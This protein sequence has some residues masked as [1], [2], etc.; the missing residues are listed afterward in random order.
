MD[1]G[2][3]QAI[4]M[5]GSG[6]AHVME[7]DWEEI[8]GDID[9]QPRAGSTL[10]KED[11]FHAMRAQQ[12]FANAAANPDV[13]NKYYAAE[14]YASTIKDVDMQKAVRPE[15]PPSPQ[16]PKTQVNI[17]IPLDKMPY[18]V[19][20]VLTEMGLQPVPDAEHDATLQGIT[21]I[22]EAADA[23]GKLAE[24]VNDGSQDSL[25]KT[26]ADRVGSDRGGAK[27]PSTA[28]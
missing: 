28:S 2:A 15:P 27:S 12:F 9:V 25:R 11:E 1:G 26:G 13:F 16:V 23:A 19:N 7:I 8:Q 6:Q 10:S 5:T 17:N 3:Q 21:K 22:G 20:P 24:P 14:V 4:T 18:L